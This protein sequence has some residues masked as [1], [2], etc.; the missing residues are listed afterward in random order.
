MKRQALIFLVA[1]FLPSLVLGW[2]A[3]RA[4]G[5]QRILIERQAADLHQAETDAIASAIRDSVEAKQRAFAESVRTLVAKDSA[6]A[7]AENYGP[8][9][10]SVWTDGGIPFAITPRGSLAYP[11]NAQARRAPKVETFLGNNGA[12]LTNARAEE[13]YQQVPQDKVESKLAQSSFDRSAVAQA[14]PQSKSK[15]AVARKQESQTAQLNNRNIIPQNDV[16]AAAPSKLTP[17]YSDFQT[18]LGGAAQGIIARFVQNDLQVIFWSKPDPASN[19]L[20][21]VA[22]GPEELARL[23]HLPENTDPETVL[24]ILDDRAHPVATAPG[25]AVR[26]WKRPFVATEIGE[27]LPHWEVALYLVNPGRLTESARLVTVTLTLLIALALAAILAGGYLAAADIRRQLDLARKKTDFVSNVSHELKTPLTSI[28][29]FAELLADN[30]VSD[31]E[32]RARY[33]RIIAGESER[34]T[35]LVNNVLDFARLEKKH[36]SYDMRPAD[37]VPLADRVCE[38]ESVRLQEAGFHVGFS[39]DLPSC[40]VRCDADAIAQVLVNLLSNAEKY[41]GETKEID[42]VVEAETGHPSMARISVLDRGPGIR[43]DLE[44]K[45]FEAF[46]RADD[47]LSSGV[48]GSGLGLTL[49]RRIARDHGGDITCRSRPGGGSIFTLT[50]PLLNEPLS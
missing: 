18:A 30:R 6:G 5:K 2:L 42:V 40:P 11:S 41:S 23:V 38:S 24:A 39:C 17:E 10:A 33:L 16:Q 3:L 34:L 22:L 12:F 21:G 50:L 36:K 35:R 45:I 7:V 44:E 48:Q 25:G 13:V 49:A 26:D 20:F 1:I 47:S 19:W 32:K 37:L 31:P 28:R 9:L 8:L 27:V 15:D 29:M 14:A 46:F 4:A 43:A